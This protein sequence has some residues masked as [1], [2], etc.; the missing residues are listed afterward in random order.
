MT[1]KEVQIVD[2]W[3]R[4][5]G[6]ITLFVE[7]LAAAR[8]FYGRVF[9]LPIAVEEHNSA[10]YNFGNT[11]IN[12]VTA[13][14]AATELVGERGVADPRAGARH[15]FTIVVDDVDSACAELTSRGVELLIPPTD[16]PWGA[17][18]ASF[19]DPAGNIWEVA[20]FHANRTLHPATVGGYSIA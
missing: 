12:L 10:V 9:N 19:T 16:R 20:N 3:P 7:D 15:Q 14:S 11:L 6:A 13:D 8:E 4:G 1:T 17:R 5:I 2:A 18:T